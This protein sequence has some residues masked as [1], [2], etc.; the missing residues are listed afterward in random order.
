[1]PKKVYIAMK[2]YFNIIFFF[3]T[4]TN[5]SFAVE[6]KI[7]WEL[8]SKYDLKTKTVPKEVSTV[9]GKDVTLKGFIV[10]LD[11]QSLNLKEFLL[12]PYIPS[13]SHVPPPADN[14]IV[15]V[16]LEK[17]K[18]YKLSWYPVEVKGTLNLSKNKTLSGYSIIAKQIKELK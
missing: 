6:T 15:L 12:M 16:T 7:D 5:I 3:L 9:M 14:Q 17:S 18:T 1:M 10:P 11:Y 4:I 2:F 13:C 8:L